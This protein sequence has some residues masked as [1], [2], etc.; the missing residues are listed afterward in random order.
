MTDIVA[1]ANIIQQ[2]ETDFRSPTSENLANRMGASINYSLKRNAQVLELH[3][4]GWHRLTQISD[5][6]GFKYIRRNSA[7]NAYVLSNQ[8]NGS[9]GAISVNAEVYDE[10]GV[11]L[12]NLFSTA[13]S[14][15]SAVDT[16]G[17]EGRYSVGR[18]VEDSTDINSGT[19]KV[20]GTLNFTTLNEGYFLRFFLVSVQT[21][22]AG[23]NFQLWL[24]ETA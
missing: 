10:S 15:D 12:G 11:S 18:Y 2:E 19:N 24:R 1:S 21:D 7:I 23:F 13:P 9:A 17:A 8:I 16:G 5:Y 4:E 14:I 22:G 20:V 3:G 6:Q